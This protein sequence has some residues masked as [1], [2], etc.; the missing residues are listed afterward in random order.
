MFEKPVV[1]FFGCMRGVDGYTEAGHY[2][3]AS[4]GTRAHPTVFEKYPDGTLCP[5]GGNRGAAVLHQKEGWTAIGF[6]DCTGDS[7]SGSNS[8]FIVH[9][10]YTFEEMCQLAAEAYP[11]LWKRFGKVT[12]HGTNCPEIQG[13]VVKRVND[14]TFEIVLHGYPVTT[15]SHDS[16]G[17]AGIETVQSAVETIAKILNLPFRKE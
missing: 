15:L 9:G 11:A 16:D 8:N 5:E 12:L 3:R 14:E 13:F 6:W 7:R 4:N 2:W 17:W 1:Y 10:T